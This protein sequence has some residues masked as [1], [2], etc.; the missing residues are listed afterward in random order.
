MLD[1]WLGIGVEYVYYNM[2][3]LRGGYFLDY[4]GRRKGFTFGAGIIIN[5]S[6]RIDLGIDS[7]IYDFDTSNY[8]ISLGIKF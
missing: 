5:S 7:D 1:T 6:I 3:A 8:R 4:L 2:L